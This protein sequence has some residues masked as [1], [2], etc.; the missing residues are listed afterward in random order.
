MCDRCDDARQ[1]NWDEIR[2]LLNYNRADDLQGPLSTSLR[3]GIE[4]HEAA[5]GPMA[6]KAAVTDAIR[7]EMIASRCAIIASCAQ[8]TDMHN[9]PI[10]HVLGTWATEI[11]K[12]ENP[13]LS[14]LHEIFGNKLHIVRGEPDDDDA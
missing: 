3:E 6:E 8:T 1:E 14:M 12:Q 13:F 7:A 11:L 10:S 5:N 2:D 9:K 4:Q